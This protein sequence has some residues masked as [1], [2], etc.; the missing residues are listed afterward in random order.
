MITTKH[1]VDWFKRPRKKTSLLPF[2]LNNEGNGQALVLRYAGCNLKCSLCYAWTYSW[3]PQ[4]Y[5]YQC[6]TQVSR[7]ALVNLPAAVKRKIVWVRIQGGEPCLNYSRILNTITFAGQ[8]LTVVYQYG[9]NYYENVRAVIQTNGVAFSTLS[10]AQLAGIS[11]HLNHV[12]SSL[13]KGK[14]VFEV[15]FKSSNDPKLLDSQLSGFDVLLNQLFIPLWKNGF[16]SVAV[17][18]IAGLGPSIDFR[19][20]WLVPIDSSFLPKE[21]PLFETSTWC[22]S[23]ENMFKNFAQN[24]VPSYSAYA[25]FRNNRKTNNGQKMAIEEFEPNEFQTSWIS[26]YAGKYSQLN[27]A[28]T[29]AGDILRKLNDNPDRQWY[30][31]FSRVNHWLRVLEKIPVCS[32]SKKL[33]AK[34]RNM[35][36]TFYPSHPSGHYPYL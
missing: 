3:F 27:V 36:N 11:N 25:D 6:R 1:C 22:S 17:Y 14:I 34:V 4:Q 24:V 8:A 21:I 15:S 5:G 33:L 2:E 13:D 35:N 18:P 23:F 12:L 32:D 20:V 26:G 30:A 19:N 16:D 29:P 31:L 10:N 7:I 9:L 28:V